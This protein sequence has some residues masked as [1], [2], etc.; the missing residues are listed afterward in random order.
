MHKSGKQGLS[1]SFSRNI[2]VKQLGPQ[3]V[4]GWVTTEHSR[5]SRG[6]CRY[7]FCKI[8]EAEK[9]M[10]YITC[11][12]GK[13]ITTKCFI[14]IFQICS[15]MFYNRCRTV[16]AKLLLKSSTKWFV[17]SVGVYIVLYLHFTFSTC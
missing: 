12:W 17:I 8:P 14:I 15:T 2:E 9:R 11:F 6:C 3:L 7:T 1:N 5:V 10:A 16:F 4:L 13:K